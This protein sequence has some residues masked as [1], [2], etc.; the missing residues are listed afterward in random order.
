METGIVPRQHRRN[1][2]DSLLP[3]REAYEWKPFFPKGFW[4]GFGRLLPIREAYEWKR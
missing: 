2:G 4:E 3:I 1:R